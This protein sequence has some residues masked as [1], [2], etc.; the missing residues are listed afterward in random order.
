LCGTVQ[1]FIKQKENKQKEHPKRKRARLEG[2]G[3]DF[4]PKNKI[5]HVG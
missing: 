2:K 4:D 5:R 1:R 3:W